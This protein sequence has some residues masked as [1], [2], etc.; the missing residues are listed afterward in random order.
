[1][2]SA[3][4]GTTSFV[5]SPKLPYNDILSIGLGGP[6]SRRNPGPHDAG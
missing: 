6:A 2:I 4:L 1:M 3:E 5:E